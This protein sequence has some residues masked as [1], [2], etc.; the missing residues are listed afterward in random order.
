MTPQ[1]KIALVSAADPKDR[2]TWSGSTFFMGSALERQVGRVDYIGP[3]SIPGQDFKV[4]LARLI[5]RISGKRTYP[6]RT[7]S[8]AKHFAQEIS[9]QLAERS[10]DL[11]F[12]PAASVEIA[13]LE[14]E[15][16]IIYISDA[17]F[18]LMQE[19][20]PIFSS[21]PPASVE[22]EQFFERTALDR[23]R[24]ILFPSQW[25]ARSAVD[26]YGIARDKISL[27]PFGANLDREPDRQA[28]LGRN[29][30]AKIKI[31][32]LAKE[33]QRKGGAIA[34]D[35]LRNLEKM[36]VAAELTVCGVTPPSGESHPSMRVVPYLDKNIPGDR[37]QF[38][39][40]LSESHLLLLPT[41]TE[42][43]GVVFCEANAY[44]LPVFATRVGGI[45]AIV[46]DGLNG[47]LLPLEA[48]GKDFAERIARA[49]L[50]PETYQ[51]LNRGA[52]E[53]Y[54][55]VL[56]WDA[57]AQTVRKTIQDTLRI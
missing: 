9:H 3:I 31:L 15:I 12:A 49:C 57:W 52:R 26:H 33:W 7:L 22:A 56:N 20:Y 35:T 19:V 18:A 2:R 8:A 48:E 45:P 1:L 38:E 40:I 28:V 42:C 50:N 46:E 25:A 36:G 30:G 24:L 51:T 41:R 29:V 53:R 39:R 14:T 32:F 55:K 16:P 10:Y 5:H 21:M 47:Y 43:Y 17:T 23:A 13:Y 6:F 37:N 34:L 4:K 44:G 27:I 54:E 11:I